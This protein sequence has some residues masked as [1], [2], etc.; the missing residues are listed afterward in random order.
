MAGDWIPIRTN[1][2]RSREVLAVARV[3][4]R[5]RFEVVGLL[6]T[7]WGWASGETVDGLLARLTCADLCE[8]VGGDSRFWEAV[9]AE[10]WLAGRDDG[11]MIPNFDRWLANGAKSRLQKA[12]RQ[13]SWRSKQ[14][15]DASTGD[16]PVDGGASTS[17][18][19][20]GEER[21]EEERTVQ[22]KQQEARKGASKFEKPSVDDVQS[23]CEENGI[24]IDAQQF[25][26]HYDANGWKVG[27]AAM[28]DWKAAVR[29]WGRR[30]NEFRKDAH[31]KPRYTDGPGQVHP[32]TPRRF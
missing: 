27:R 23:F 28:K 14:Q 16:A 19:T 1:L 24:T 29:N 3:T 6:V 10:G 12:K 26:D 31:A 20:T 4:G 2:A 7:F 15:G 8:T 5:S 22:K 13:A 25:I 32:D 9:E 21:T 18:S 17:A 11:I 30:Q